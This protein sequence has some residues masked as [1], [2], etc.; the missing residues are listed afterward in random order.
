[1]KRKF[2]FFIADVSFDWKE[3]ISCEPTAHMLLKIQIKMTI[4]S[5]SAFDKLTLEWSNK[6]KIGLQL[7]R[8]PWS[9]RLS[10][11][12]FFYGKRTLN[13]S[14]QHITSSMK[15]TI[16]ESF[17]NIIS[18]RPFYVGKWEMFRA[19]RSK[20]QIC[21]VFTK[22]KYEYR[23]TLRHKFNSKLLYTYML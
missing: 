5:S 15:M 2:Q 23:K 3:I 14:L 8:A 9:A 4:W 12:H 10:T 13:E 16:S 18:C 1:M 20:F 17:K 21:Q 6:L 19:L 11:C 22:D 7:Q